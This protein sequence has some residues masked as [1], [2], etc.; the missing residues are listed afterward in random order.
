MNSAV[1]PWA[2]AHE[3]AG[4][5][6]AHV[7]GVDVDQRRDPRVRGVEHLEAAV[8]PP[9]VDHV[10]GHP[11]ADP[12]GRLHQQPVH[13]GTVQSP[14]SGEPGETAADDDDVHLNGLRHG[15][16]S[17]GDEQGRP[18]RNRGPRVKQAEE[19]E[20]PRLDSNQ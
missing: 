15:H 2:A 14:G 18:Q 11:P 16:T 3:H 8:E 5:E 4:G 17:H 10:G 7:Q 9:A 13:P 6:V 12:V 1:Q 19:K 20:L